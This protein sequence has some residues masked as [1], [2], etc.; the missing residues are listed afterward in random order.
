MIS[1]INKNKNSLQTSANNFYKS[2]S[3]YKMVTL[4]MPTLTPIKSIYHILAE[5]EQVKSAIEKSLIGLK[6]QDIKLRERKEKLKNNKNLTESEIEIEKLEI[7]REEIGI[8]KE[9]KYLQGSIRR[10]SFLTT[11][12]QQ[13][14]KKMGK[15]KITE[16]DYEL[17][18]QKHHVM[19]AFKQ[20]LIAARARDGLIDEGN[21]IYF[22]DLGINGHMAQKE[23]T[24]I[25]EKEHQ[26]ISQ[27]IE[28]N[29]ELV[30]N[31]LEECA[32]KYL[33]C[34]LEFSQKRGFKVFDELSTVKQNDKEN[35]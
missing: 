3:Q 25:I 20:A 30:L 2:D 9:K 24:Y 34:A 23:I 8:D 13:M 14:L 18:E 1:H 29:H 10:L 32:N 4:N 31:W 27:G 12:H 6:I 5:V 15:D 28:P 26:L 22:F 7:L 16:K 19:T 33:N 21:M 11:Q 17:D 35:S